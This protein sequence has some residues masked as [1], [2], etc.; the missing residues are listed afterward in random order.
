[1][2]IEVIRSSR[3]TLGAQI[4]NGR[5]IVRA[6][7]YATEKDINLFLQKN[8]KWFEKHIASA[9]EREKEKENVRRLSKEDIKSL[10]DRAKKIIP[11]R[12]AYYAPIVGVKYGKITVRMQKTRWGSCSAKGN[13]NFNCLLMLTPPE[14]TDSVV[15]HELCHIKEM[16]HSKRF[17]SE[18]TR[19]FPSYFEQKKWLRKN[20][21]LILASADK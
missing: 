21:D 2:E 18:V 14:V 9:N 13:L 10:Y 6:P 3:K 5:I 11:E 7:K 17:Y 19:V 4:K 8:R 12:V 1:M 16:N 15:V 20:G